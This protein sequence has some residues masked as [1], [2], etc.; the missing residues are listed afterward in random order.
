MRVYQLGEGT[1]EVAV[2]GGIHGDEP[3]GAR[4]VERI[5]AD[6]PPVERPVRLVVANEAALERSVRYV[7]ADLNRSFG[8][9]VPEDAHEYDL[10]RDLA[11]ALEGCTVLS[12]HSTQS[13]AEP[14]GIV[15]GVDGPVPDIAPHLSVA[16]LVDVDDDE[17]RLFA[18]EATELVEVEAGRQGSD[19]AAE[20][21]YRLAREFLTATG[22][23][24]GETASRDVPV[25]RLDDRIEKPPAERYEVFAENFAEVEAGEPFAAVDGDRLVAERPFYPVLM[26]AEGYEDVLGYV[27]DRVGVLDGDGG[28]VET[29]AD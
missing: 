3:C 14:F 15:N 20:N 9:D 1:P 28:V 11:E 23:L 25:Y 5:V 13:Y 17:G 6:D 10:A 12:L 29:G 4:A 19:R 7:D 8:D 18:L 26:S 2:V 16:A 21:A 24:P 27:G 22:A